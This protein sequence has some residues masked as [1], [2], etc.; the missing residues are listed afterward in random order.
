MD[1]SFDEIIVEKNCTPPTV[2]VADIEDV[3]NL[4]DVVD[5]P[6]AIVEQVE[7]QTCILVHV[8]YSISQDAMRVIAVTCQKQHTLLHTTCG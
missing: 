1:A 2:L 4:V 6:L 7:A 8:V 3:V 5:P